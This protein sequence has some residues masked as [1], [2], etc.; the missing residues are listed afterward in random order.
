MVFDVLFKTGLSIVEKRCR[1]MQAQKKMKIQT[2]RHCCRKDIHQISTLG[3]CMAAQSSKNPP[4][5][6]KDCSK[7]PHFMGQQHPTSWVR[8]MKASRN[9]RKV[10]PWL[11]TWKPTLGCFVFSMFFHV[12]FFHVFFMSGGFGHLSTWE[13]PCDVLDESS[14][15]HI[16][17]ARLALWKAGLGWARQQALQCCVCTSK[18]TENHWTSSCVTL[19]HQDWLETLPIC[20]MFD[21]IPWLLYTS[22]RLPL[23]DPHRL[24]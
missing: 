21:D 17:C 2:C 20:Q 24:A 5:I 12:M 8:P 14:L 18:A 16:R 19:S 10:H 15:G 11:V 4:V 13:H 23:A 9:Y 22:V 7:N 1:I 3:V 6:H